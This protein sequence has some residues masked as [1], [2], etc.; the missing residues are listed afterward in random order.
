MR[1]L[2]K[3]PVPVPSVVWLS[4]IVGFGDALQHTPLAEIVAPPSVVIVPPDWAEVSVMF[5]MVEVVKAGTAGA[6]VENDFP[7]P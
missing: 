7:L 4:A 3:M 1:L 6:G 5:E 2:E